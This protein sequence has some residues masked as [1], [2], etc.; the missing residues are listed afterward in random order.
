MWNKRGKA[1]R[2]GKNVGFVLFRRLFPSGNYLTIKPILEVFDFIGYFYS[3]F[4]LFSFSLLLSSFEWI[5]RSD[6]QSSP[7]L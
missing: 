1:R 2:K 4:I 6:D 3:P 7:T 5:L